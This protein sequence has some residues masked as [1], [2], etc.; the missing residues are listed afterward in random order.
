MADRRSRAGGRWRGRVGLTLI[1]AGVLLGVLVAVSVKWWV[2]YGTQTWL[3]DF[4]DGT[5]YTQAI[6]RNEWGRPLDGWCG[7][8]NER[9]LPNGEVRS[10]SWTWWTWG[11]RPSPEQGSAYTVWPLSPLLVVSGAILAWP[12]CRA[13]RRRRRNQCARGGYSRA[14]LDAAALCPECGATP[15]GASR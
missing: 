9:Y 6:E 1:G 12:V 15:A 14:G 13:A 8:V 11:V 10:W 4:G 5:L 3:A 2:G 7:G